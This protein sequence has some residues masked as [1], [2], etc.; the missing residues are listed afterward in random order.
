MHLLFECTIFLSNFLSK[1]TTS[2]DCDTTIQVLTSKLFF[3]RSYTL[4]TR[5]VFPNP[6]IPDTV[7]I[8]LSCSLEYN[9]SVNSFLLSSI[10]TRSS[11]ARRQ[12]WDRFLSI[13]ASGLGVC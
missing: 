4:L 2:Y 11:G 10:P 13:S 3:S 12:S 9:Q 8:V 5:V 7:I 6:P 1:S